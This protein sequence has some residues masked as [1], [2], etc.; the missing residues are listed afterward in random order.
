MTNAVNDDP[1][2][3]RPV[4]DAVRVRN[5]HEAAKIALVGDASAVW[6][7]GEWINEALGERASM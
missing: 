6:I 5:Y 2:R 1:G 7:V 4:E 3:F